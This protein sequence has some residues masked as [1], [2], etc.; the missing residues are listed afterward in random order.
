MATVNISSIA[1]TWNNAGTTFTAIG[2]DVT[3]TASNA[4]SLLMDLQ[5]GGAS[6]FSV[7]KAGE[8]G[9]SG[10][11]LAAGGAVP[12]AGFNAFSSGLVQGYASG[13]VAMKLTS[14][15]L[16]ISGGRLDVGGSGLETSIVHP[17]RDVLTQARGANQQTLAAATTYTDASNYER[18]AIENGVRM[19]SAGTGAAN[20]DLPLVPLGTGR[21]QFG[22]HAAISSETLSGYIE[23]KDAGGTVRK[24]AVVS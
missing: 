5:V 11:N 22:T 3:D 7:D 9:A 16:Q 13:V 8:V 14:S 1:K 18:T 4:A 24:L 20:I 23:I 12:T 6:K 15:A 10:L 21:V 17:S 2:L 19:Q